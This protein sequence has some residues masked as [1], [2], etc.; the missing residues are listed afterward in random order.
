MVTAVLSPTLMWP[1]P[2]VSSFVISADLIAPN[3][4]M[5]FKNDCLG[6][7]Y[8]GPS[9]IRASILQRNLASVSVMTL[10]VKARKYHGQLK[11]RGRIR[12]LIAMPFFIHVQPLRHT[13]I[14]YC[15]R[16]H[17]LKEL[18]HG[19][20]RSATNVC[21]ISPA[22]SAKCAQ[23][24][25]LSAIDSTNC[26]DAIQKPLSGGSHWYHSER[27]ASILRRKLAIAST[28]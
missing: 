15:G 14:K 5:Q 1:Q 26:F 17:I 28:Q 25:D 21:R 6:V 24:W 8:W 3:A 23:L 16:F 9:E 12:T 2:N 22:T 20:S 7:S 4:L 19:V 13:G 18:G 11:L 27:P 10:C